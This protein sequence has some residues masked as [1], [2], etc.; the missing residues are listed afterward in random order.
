MGP[1]CKG[2]V[3]RNRLFVKDKMGKVI[4]ARVSGVICYKNTTTGIV[5]NLQ[6]EYMNSNMRPCS[7]LPVKANKQ[8]P[9]SKILET[10]MKKATASIMGPYTRKTRLSR[11]H[12]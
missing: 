9:S 5:F 4:P 12:R 2:G 10:R 7:A 3:R 8:L 11:K 6:T 1:V